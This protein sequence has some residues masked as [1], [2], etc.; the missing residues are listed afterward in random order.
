MSDVWYSQW[1]R[2]D[3]SVLYVR[4]KAAETGNEGSREPECRKHVKDTLFFGFDGSVG[5]YD[6]D[7]DDVN[8]FNSHRS[9]STGVA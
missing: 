8:L 3:E 9:T 2:S 1:I 7:V 6:W 5:V 4:K